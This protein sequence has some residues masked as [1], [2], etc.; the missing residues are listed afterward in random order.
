M[1]HISPRPLGYV[2][3]AK[4]VRT[5][6]A[7]LLT[8]AALSLTGV[9]AAAHDDNFR[10]PGLTLLILIIASLSFI[11]SMQLHFYARQY[12][13]SIADIEDWHGSDIASADPDR[14]GALLA[15]QG[16]DF[17]KWKKLNNGATG[18][19]NAGTLLLASGIALALIPHVG[20]EMEWRWAAVALIVAC[21]LI[22]LAWIIYLYFESKQYTL[23]SAER[24][25]RAV[26]R[27][28]AER[29]GKSDQRGY[30]TPGLPTDL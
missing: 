19:F 4:E 30:Y 9:V 7:P 2:E 21:T 18:S 11:A 28:E 10:W 3:A 22:D 12:L 14:Y 16:D 24:E 29:G 23:R 15:Q 26:N 25:M 8:A 1:P 5:I 20:R 27:P 6:A 17:S 13:Y